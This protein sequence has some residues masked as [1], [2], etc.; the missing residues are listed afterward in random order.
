[1]SVVAFL[2]SKNIPA[3]VI[4]GNDEATNKKIAKALGYTADVFEVVHYVPK[5]GKGG[6]YLKS[7]LTGPNGQPLRSQFF[8][9]LCDGET[10]S[11]EG[12]AKKQG[13]LLAVANSA[14]DALG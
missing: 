10:L 5:S 14:A 13:I 6:M 4:A 12:E 7:N 2:Q 1:M 11:P 9:R 3:S 8:E